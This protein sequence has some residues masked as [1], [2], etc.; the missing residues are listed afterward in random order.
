M[1]CIKIRNFFQNK[2]GIITITSAIIFPLIIILMAIVFEM[3]NIYLEKERLQAVIDRALLDTVTMIK[4]KNIEDVVK[5]VGPVNT[6]WTKN[7]K[8]ELEHSDFSS[9]VQNVIDDT[10]M[11]LESDSNFK[12][13]SITAISQYKMPFKIC[14]IHLLCPKNK[15]VTVPVLSSM[16]IGRNEGSDIDLMI[17]LDVSSSMD[18]NFMKPEEAPCS[19]LEVAK[20]SIR[21]MLEDFRK[22]PNYANVFRTG[23][24][25]FNDM[26]QFPM[27]LKRGLKRIYNDIKKYRAFGSTNSYVGMKY[28]WEQLYGNPQDTKDRKKIVIFLTDGENMII[29]ATRKTIELCN[30]MK[31]KKAV[32]YSIALAVDNKE[33]L[34]GCSS[35]GNVY[36]AD[37]AQSLV[38]AYSL[39]GKDVMKDEYIKYVR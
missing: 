1:Y 36:A 24:V 22:V 17:V 34:Q 28:A 13:L 11:K 35:S 30:D 39:I 19:R 5:N 29:N 21:K 2:R 12:T 7:L 18:D 8:Y 32:I 37:D 23:S 15:Y 9:D 27:P 10:S 3:S 25:G 20:K 31:K 33:V 38:Q 26:V 14:N 6:I 4:L 16:K